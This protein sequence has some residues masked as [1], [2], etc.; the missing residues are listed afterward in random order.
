M[1]SRFQRDRLLFATFQPFFD[2]FCDA[3]LAA[4]SLASLRWYRENRR[5]LTNQSVNLSINTKQSIN[6]VTSVLVDRF[7]R[8]FESR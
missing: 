1:K 2:C 3:S 4:V 6:H 5:G 7:R 8:R